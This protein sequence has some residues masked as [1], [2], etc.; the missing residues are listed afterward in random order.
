MNNV[1]EHNGYVGKIEFSSDDNCFFGKIL[2]INDL[3]SFEGSSVDEIKSAFSEAVDDYLEMCAENGKEPEKSY[4]GS[5]NVRIDPVLHRQ[6][7]SFAALS[8]ISLNQFVESAIADK[9]SHAH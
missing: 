2:G 7:A 5:F 8:N 9:V 4:K 1:L 6:A 3:V